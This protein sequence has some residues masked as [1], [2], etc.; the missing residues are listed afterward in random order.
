MRLPCTP[1]ALVYGLMFGVLIGAGL[2]AGLGLI[3]GLVLAAIARW[4]ALN[5]PDNPR[6]SLRDIRLATIPFDIVVV[7]VF[8]LPFASVFGVIPP[9]I[10]AFTIYNLSLGFAEYADSLR[11]Q[12]PSRNTPLNVL[13]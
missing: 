5:Q 3:N 13:S 11:T 1:I 4:Y 7:L 9:F 6:D 2:G 12:I 8:S 10:A